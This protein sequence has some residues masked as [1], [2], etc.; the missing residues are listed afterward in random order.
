MISISNLKFKMQF[1]I[2]HIMMKFI[3]NELRLLYRGD[4]L[5]QLISYETMKFLQQ[6]HAYNII[7]ITL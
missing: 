1:F 6:A 7:N 3:F 5:D 4:S 2:F